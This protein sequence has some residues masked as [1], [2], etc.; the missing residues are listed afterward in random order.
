MYYA[1]EVHCVTVAAVRQSSHW[2]HIQGTIVLT[3]PYQ[4][5]PVYSRFWRDDGKHGEGL[6]E[7]FC[8]AHA[9]DFSNG[10]VLT[11]SLICGSMMQSACGSTTQLQVTL[12]TGYGE[13]DLVEVNQTI[14]ETL[15]AGNKEVDL[16]EDAAGLPDGF[17]PLSLTEQS[18]WLWWTNQF[19]CLTG[20]DPVSW[21]ND[22][23]WS[24]QHT[25]NAGRMQHSNAYDD[26]PPNGPAGENLAQGHPNIASAVT[27]W[28]DEYHQCVWPGC[29]GGMSGHFTAMVWRGA[30]SMGCGV[31]WNAGPL[32]V[33]RYKG[34]DHLDCSTPNILGCYNDQVGQPSRQW[35]ECNGGNV[36]TDLAARRDNNTWA[37]FG[38]GFAEM[39]AHFTPP[40]PSSALVIQSSWV[41]GLL[42]FT[43]MAAVVTAV[44][45]FKKNRRTASELYMTL[46]EDTA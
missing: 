26:S 32:Y 1:D 9:F 5:Q 30:T 18:D 6:H 16:A 7:R 41:T 21:S 27:D 28:Y 14:T 44:A 39:E 36:I 42:G 17:V 2:A 35:N 12:E 31:N 8:Q 38:V 45:A 15:D 20:A 3:V 11:T 25:A 29:E 4:D 13:V 37:N 23:A 40:K 46:V 10:F 43:A 34:G 24:A 22:L 19:R 33:C